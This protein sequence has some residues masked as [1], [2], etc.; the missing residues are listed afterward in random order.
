MRWVPAIAVVLAGCA[1]TPVTWTKVNGSP[2]SPEQLTLDRTVCQGEMQK[3][4]LTNTVKGGVAFDANGVYDPKSRA[5]S[6]VFT[7][8][9]AQHG[10]IK[11]NN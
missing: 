4:N 3:S 11:T 10:Y 7:G 2:P 8:C 5:L 6:Q 1:T 9:M